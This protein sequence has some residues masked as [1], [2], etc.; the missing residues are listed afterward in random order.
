MGVLASTMLIAE[1]ENT[2][3]DEKIKDAKTNAT[4]T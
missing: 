1:S 4:I 3:K 2:M